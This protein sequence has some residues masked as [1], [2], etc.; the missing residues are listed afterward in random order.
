V[1][2]SK[3][4]GVENMESLKKSELGKFFSGC[5]R[6]WGNNQPEIMCYIDQTK[7]L[8]LRIKFHV[9]GQNKST[10]EFYLN[11]RNQLEV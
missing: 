4:A 1:F 9:R 10:C 2:F 3:I 11:K 5:Y 6:I 7:Y 8:A